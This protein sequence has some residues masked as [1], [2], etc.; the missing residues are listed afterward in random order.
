MA[1]LRRRV[2][3]ILSCSVH[4]RLIRKLKEMDCMTQTSGSRDI[5]IRMTSEYM[6]MHRRTQLRHLKRLPLCVQKCFPLAF[7]C[8][9]SVTFLSS[10]ISLPRVFSKT[11]CRFQEAVPCTTA[12]KLLRLHESL[13]ITHQSLVPLVPPPLNCRDFTKA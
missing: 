13:N 5:I 4:S 3:Q 6:Y 1:M 7:P 11:A 10:L 9:G 8:E 2:S 12:S